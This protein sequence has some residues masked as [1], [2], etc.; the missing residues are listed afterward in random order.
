MIVIRFQ[1]KHTHTRNGFLRERQ[2]VSHVRVCSRVAEIALRFALI[3]L[4]PTHMHTNCD[5]LVNMN[6]NTRKK[7]HTSRRAGNA[8]PLSRILWRRVL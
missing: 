1:T 7:W 5:E 2:R 4:K 3:Q 6:A 8:R